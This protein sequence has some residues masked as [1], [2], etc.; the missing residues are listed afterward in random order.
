DDRASHSITH[1]GLAVKTLILPP[2]QTMGTLNRACLKASTGRY[3]VLIND[4]VIVR[5]PGWDTTIYR[6][7]AGFGDDIALIHVNDM[8]FQERL[9]TFPILSRKA[10]LETGICPAS[11]R[12]YR[13]DDHIYDTYYLLA[14][15]GHSRIIYLKDVV[16]EHENYVAEG[17]AHANA[18]NTFRTDDGRVYVLDPEALA[19]DSREF[20]E[21]LDDRK[22]DARKL[23]RLIEMAALNNRLAFH[24][25]SLAEIR[26]SYSYRLKCSISAA[27]PSAGPAATRKVT[28]AMVTSDLRRPHAAKC[29]SLV[30]EHTSD[31][32][33]LILDNNGSR[34][35]NHPAEMNKVLRTAKTDYVVLLDDDVYVTPGWLEGLIECVGE[36]TGIV[37]PLHRNRRG[38]I[39]YSGVYLNGDGQGTHAHTLDVPAFPRPCQCMCSAAVLIDRRK[40]GNIFFN[41]AYQKYFLDLDYALQVW[42]AG[43]EVL[44]TPR[45]IITHLGG[46]T[47]AYTTAESTA[48]GNVDRNTFG[49][50]WL[51]TGRLGRIESEIWSED[52]YLRGLTETLQRLQR[53][54]D[55]VGSKSPDE[56]RKMLKPLIDELRPVPRFYHLLAP[57]I[58]EQA[59]RCRVWEENAKAACLQATVE[60]LYPRR[61]RLVRRLRR[62]LGSVVK[63]LIAKA[64]S[65]VW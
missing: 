40:C 48:K 4:D 18:V 29:L 61:T 10:C 65:F 53:I 38:R 34:Q 51:A 1:E 36:R 41:D 30:K 31:Y 15:L 13:I 22:R 12:R 60:E 3:V 21:R 32:D 42:E 37:T 7:F 6:T 45:S 5:T 33:L 27:A 59:Y 17:A 58:Q 49:S 47:M 11:Y 55:Q 39:S 26:D 62:G 64:K 54:F 28:V 8:L 52:D 9:C 14:Y 57:L 43:Y 50:T 56:L 46:A 19:A 44:C 16:F 25:N 2:G 20:T 23:A 24:E 35:F 63:P